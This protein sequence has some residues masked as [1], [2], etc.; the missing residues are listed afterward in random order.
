[1]STGVAPR[2]RRTMIVL[3][4]ALAVAASSL[5]APASSN[6]QNTGKL[7]VFTLPFACGFNSYASQLC[8]GVK[9]AGKS[10]SPRYAVQIKT[11]TNYAD[12]TAYNN[13]LETSYQLRPSGVIGF[14]DG[15]AA[16]TPTLRSGC[17]KGIK[18]IL[19][20]SPA[21]GMGSCQS[22]FVGSDHYGMGVLDGKWLI[23][24]PP[25]SGSKEVGIVTQPPGE[26]ASTDARV[27]GF[28]TTVKAAGY[29]VV[30]TVVVT[31]L[32]SDKN[33]SL[34]TNLVTAHPQLGAI[35]SA[36]GPMGDAT[37]QALRGNHAIVQLTLD[38][39][40]S[41]IQGVLH[42]QVAANV[43]QDPF[44]EGR[45]AVTYMANVLAGKKVPKLI[46]TP[47]M[48]VDR[49]NVRRFIAKGGMR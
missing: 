44:A 5:A 32:G 4:C 10:L 8:A 38:A 41:S 25:A 18:M 33:V 15:P 12:A 3:G 43:A 11:G 49:S 29:K 26:Y 27:R 39:D 19:I 46:H 28:E 1:M 45:L 2:V 6:R 9:A 40:A 47:S 13:L 42:G 35:F 37:T 23:A 20:D 48:V 21:T 31:D 7:I 36:N 16:Q 17:A 34:V 24:H 22:S 14:V 30:A